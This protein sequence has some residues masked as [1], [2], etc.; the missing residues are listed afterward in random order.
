[1]NH[2]SVITGGQR[3][4]ERPL[5]LLNCKIFC[6]FRSNIISMLYVF[7]QEGGHWHHRNDIMLVSTNLV[8]EGGEVKKISSLKFVLTC[9]WLCFPSSSST[10]LL[11]PQEVFPDLWPCQEELPGREEGFRHPGQRWQWVYWGGRAQ[12][13]QRPVHWPKPVSACPS[14]AMR[15][16]TS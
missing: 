1:M 6:I 16:Q 4:G 14:D 15:D 5:K 10:R 12:V 2:A 3:S 13:S 9:S 8:Y 11:L 7:G